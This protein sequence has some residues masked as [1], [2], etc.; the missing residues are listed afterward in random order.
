M[1]VSDFETFHVVFTDRIGCRQTTRTT[2]KRDHRSPAQRRQAVRQKVAWAENIPTR[3]VLS[4]VNVNAG[5]QIG[6]RA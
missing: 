5:P 3:K 6:R 1:Q 4:I 2:L